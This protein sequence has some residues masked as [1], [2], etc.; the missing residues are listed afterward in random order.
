MHGAIVQVERPLYY[1]LPSLEECRAHFDKNFGGPYAWDDV[2]EAPEEETDA[3]IE[4]TTD[5]Y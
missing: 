5:V 1:R 3:P 4:E 2:E